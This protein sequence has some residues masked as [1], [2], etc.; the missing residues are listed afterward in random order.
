MTSTGTPQDDTAPSSVPGIVRSPAPLDPAQAAQVRALARRA[1]TADGVAPLSEQ[2]LLRLGDPDA[3]VE[4]LLVPA[5]DGH[6]LGYAQLDLDAAEQAKVELVVDPDARRQGL[7]TAL[8]A[9]AVARAR[10]EGASQVAVWAHGDLPAARASAHRSGLAVVREL[11]QMRLELPGRPV[12]ADDHLPAGVTVRAFVPGQDEDAWRRVN[13]RAFAQHPEQGRMTASDLR[14]RQREPWFDPAGF[15]LAERDGQLLGFVWTKV[16]AAGQLGPDEVGEIYV[17]GVDPDAQGLG[18]GGAL[19]RRGLA[20]LS[21]RGLR[22]VVLYTEAANA[23]AVRT[24]ERV[25]FARSA[26]DVM[27]ALDTHRS[28]SGATMVR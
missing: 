26:V 10:A 22:S 2:P 16:H 23:V 6:L 13:S 24:Y 4:H 3:P 28:S 7:A 25:G 5:A 27:Y 18:L 8:V 9:A 17:L 21:A 14:A 15:L 20:W 12:P 11:W 19:T 1:H